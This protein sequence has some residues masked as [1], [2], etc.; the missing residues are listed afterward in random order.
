MYDPAVGKRKISA[1]MITKNEA[2]TIERALASLA[3]LA[4]EIIVLDTGSTDETPAIAR[5]MGAQVYSYVWHDDFAAARNASLRYARNEWIFVLDADEAV[6][7]RDHKKIR[8]IMDEEGYLGAWLYQRNYFE[9]PS[10]ENWCVNTTD[11]EEGKQ[12]A[13]YSDVPVL[14]FFRNLPTICFEGIVHEVVDDCL[15]GRKVKFTDVPIHH[16]RRDFRGE[17]TRE[18]QEKYLALLLKAYERTPD[19]TKVLFLL[20]RQ[21]L[22]LEQYPHAAG[23]LARAVELGSR[24]EQVHVNLALAYFHCTL[25]QEAI[26]TLERV[27]Q[28]N[29]R[30][31]EALATIGISYYQVG[32]VDK[33]INSLVKAITLRPTS[34]VYKF[35]LAAIYFKEHNFA[36]AEQELKELVRLCP[37]FSRA[38]Y[39]LFHVYAEQQRINEAQEL[40]KILARMDPSLYEKVKDKA[41]ALAASG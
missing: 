15:E 6:S 21:F 14:R 38:Y 10:A 13:G 16:Y 39:L 5:H 7:P 23:Y 1:C 30:Y 24:S 22:D 41:A 25:Y 33:A 31:A 35:N 8:S 3:G 2:H 34:V 4:D 17:K 26:E 28:F 40:V 37:K 36:S 32:V 27:I 11:Y 20:G 19:D 18:K 29:P 9:D 12:F